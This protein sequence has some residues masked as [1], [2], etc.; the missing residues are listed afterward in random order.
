ML[1]I[2]KEFPGIKA[3]DQVTLRVKKGEI[4]ALLGEN[5]AG[6]STLMSILF[7]L[8]KADEGTIK[9]NGETVTIENP[10]DANALGIGMVHQHFK[11]VDRFTVTQN[12]ILGYED[13][14][15]G[16]LRY[17]N[18]IE[19]IKDLSKKYKLNVDPTAYI[20]DISVGQQ[21]RV[22]ILKT[23]Y[24]EA[25][26]LIL[27]EPTASLTPQEIQEL[28]GIMKNMTKE[29]KSIVFITH[30]LEE[31][32]QVADRCTILRK[33]KHIDTV[34]V[35]DTT[36]EQLAEK[37]VGRKVLFDLDKKKANVK[38]TALVLDNVSVLSP[39]TKQRVVN[40]MNFELKKGEILCIAGIEGNGQSELIYGITGMY[41][42]VEGTVRLHDKDITK[43][44]IRDRNVSG[45]SHIPE[46]RHKHGLILDYTLEY[47]LVMQSYFTE[48]FQRKGFLKF[49]A[50]REHA[51]ELIER[52]DIRTSAGPVTLVR[53]MSGGNQQKAIL[54]R[55]IDRDTDVLIAVQPTRGLDV[56]AIEY[57]HRELLA[58]RDKGKAVLLVS[59]ELDEVFNLSDRILVMYEGENVG[60]FD[61]DKITEQELGLYM[62]GSKRGE[63][64]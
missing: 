43:T 7:G 48:A 24:R 8:Y 16:F 3:N 5:G 12:I 22:E 1:D 26:I 35:K 45:L 31:I 53:S 51:K 17:D 41:P 44:S 28:M 36:N 19:K 18:A 46:D 39:V 57:I 34:E 42:V 20:E 27:D 15:R 54:G 30:K 2:T 40:D 9:V 59:Y 63:T 13:T 38:E 49:D 14:R 50:I 56:G 47:N 37:M 61:P 52:F 33:G 55:E 23:L 29:G 21:Q 60:V 58:Q 25:D 32:R 11:L 64:A 6:K 4:H 10:N 62:A